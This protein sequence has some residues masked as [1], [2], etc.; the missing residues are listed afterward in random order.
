MPLSTISVMR[1]CSCSAEVNPFHP[2][3]NYYIGDEVTIH[4]A[5]GWVNIKKCQTINNIRPKLLTWG[6]T[7][8]VLNF[9][10]AVPAAYGER[11]AVNCNRRFMRPIPVLDMQLCT[12]PLP[13]SSDYKSTR[14]P[15]APTSSWRPLGLLDSVLRA[16]RM[17]RPYDQCR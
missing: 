8:V 4:V 3:L 6:L 9:A 1:D 10:T 17:I 15:P 5:L 12:P 2:S 16:S 13:L 7:S 14:G 11:V